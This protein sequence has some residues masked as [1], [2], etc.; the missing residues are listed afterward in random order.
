VKNRAFS[1]AR[2][3]HGHL[4]S[5]T[6]SVDCTRKLKLADVAKAILTINVYDEYKKKDQFEN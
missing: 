4:F 1:I 2:A 6:W 3:A 5:K